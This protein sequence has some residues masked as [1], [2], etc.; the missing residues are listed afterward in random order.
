MANQTT[1]IQA[2]ETI[3]N[4]TVTEFAQTS[5]MV[6]QSNN[7]ITIYGDAQ[8]GATAKINNPMVGY[9]LDNWI[10]D[11]DNNSGAIQQTVRDFSVDQKVGSN[12]AI[13]GL[14]KAIEIAQN[15]ELLK[16]QVAQNARVMAERVE[17]RC[18]EIAT[19][20]T[21]MAYYNGDL[22]AA[23]SNAKLSEVSTLSSI[24]H[25]YDNMSE[26]GLQGNVDVFLDHRATRRIVSSQQAL[27]TPNM[28]DNSV[29]KWVAGLGVEG[30]DFF[31]SNLLHT[32][33][34][35]SIGDG[36]IEL[37]LTNA[38]ADGKTL[39]FDAGVANAGA[40]AA[41]NDIIEFVIQNL[42]G[43][44]NLYP[45]TMGGTNADLSSQKVQAR[46]TADAAVDA[47]GSIVIQVVANHDK[48]LFA[49]D[50]ANGTENGFANISRAF[51]TGA[52]ADKARII[53]SHKSGV[54]SLKDSLYLAMA[55]L[56]SLAPFD[57]STQTVDGVSLRMGNVTN[58]DTRACNYYIDGLYGIYWQPES[59][60][61][62]CLPA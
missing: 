27:F 43:T 58:G 4:A 24:R 33:T 48:G 49:R 59:T 3:L 60:M 42:D 41:K 26:R 52:N 34:A 50:E 56:P 20:N 40:E 38:S 22:P 21:F 39:T 53:P 15:P 25:A 45:L 57:S 36:N 1:S 18:S 35:G 61:R 37:T 23:G 55:D 29:Q 44:D 17:Q 28:N 30:M 7:D 5:A 2:V 11:G 51:V 62:I 12:T 6:H 31:K 54:M 32:H 47:A 16:R 8:I 9:A 46:V 13:T 19:E 14:Q 10:S